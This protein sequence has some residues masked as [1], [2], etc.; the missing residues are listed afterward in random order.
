MVYTYRVQLETDT[1]TGQI[2]AT[3]PALNDLSDFGE[4]V[5]E[6]LEN[7]KQLAEFALRAA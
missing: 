4:T 3:L 1:H 5:E 2:C 7:L 6:A